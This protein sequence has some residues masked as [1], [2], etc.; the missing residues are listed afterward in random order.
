MFE[1]L[2]EEFEKN[3]NF[4]KSVLNS[5]LKEVENLIRECLS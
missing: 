3:I 4:K 1:I 2:K 5:D